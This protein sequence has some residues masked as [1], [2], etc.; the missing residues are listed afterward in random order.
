M[1]KHLRVKSIFQLIDRKQFNAL[2]KMWDMDKWVQSFSTW[3]QTQA[4]IYCFVMR[5]ES[6]PDVEINLR[7]PD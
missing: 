4:L 7:I 1:Q 3:E 2:V 6:F 5:L